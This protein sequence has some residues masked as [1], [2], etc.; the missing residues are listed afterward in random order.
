MSEQ[1]SNRTDMILPRTET[2][3]ELYEIW[4]KV[5]KV[6]DLS[7]TDHFLTLGGNSLL[8]M[9]LLF[10][11]EMQYDICEW[12]VEDAYEAPTIEKMAK[13]VEDYLANAEGEEAA[14]EA[15]EETVKEPVEAKKSLLDWVSENGAAGKT[16]Y[17]LTRSQRGLWFIQEMDPGSYAYNLDTALKMKGDLDVPKLEQAIHEVIRRHAA[18]RTVFVERDGFPKQVVLDKLAYELPVV[19]A[20]NLS[21]EEADQL[22]R[23]AIR[24]DMSTPFD[25]TQWPLFRF[26]LI[27]TGERTFYFYVVSHHILLD[28]MSLNLLFRELSDIYASYVTGEPRDLPAVDVQLPEFAEWQKE[29]LEKP[30]F[31]KMEEYWL[32]RLAKPIPVI[33]L[34]IDLPRPARNSYHGV[35][36]SHQLPTPLMDKMTEITEKYNASLYMVMLSAY[37]VWLYSVT[38]QKDLIV[39]MSFNGRTEPEVQNLI[40]YFSNAMPVR[41]NIDGIATFHD[42]LNFVRKNVL[43]AIPN[44][45]YPFDLLVEKVNPDRDPSRPVLYSTVFDSLVMTRTIEGLETEPVVGNKV[46]TVSDLTWNF[47]QMKGR[48]VFDLIYNVTLFE[49]ETVERFI[50]QYETV[51]EAIAEDL[52]TPIQ[53]I[54]K[55]LDAEIEVDVDD[56]F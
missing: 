38:N 19:D 3:Q 25:L 49:R 47:L 20:G 40:G 35:T 37:Y 14:D 17:E 23:K 29:Q 16:E 52:N 24:D 42:L 8:A 34:P 21:D 45:A 26:K 10:E 51:L 41:V 54:K 56:L 32:N 55:R 7:V 5:L 22:V 13:K 11:L 9:E 27:K 28:G 15:V 4:K 53:A 39:G 46:Q 31:R 36:I 43:E 33:D 30:E 18:M 6:A 2:E 50:A 48:Y 12:E 1:T 44:Q